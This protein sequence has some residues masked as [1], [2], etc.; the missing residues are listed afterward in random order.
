MTE[1]ETHEKFEATM[2]AVAVKKQGDAQF[3]TA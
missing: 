3:A 2:S 1:G